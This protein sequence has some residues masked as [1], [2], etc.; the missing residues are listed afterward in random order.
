MIQAFVSF[1]NFSDSD[2]STKK[3]AGI[4][5]DDSWQNPAKEISKRKTLVFLF[6]HK[7]HLFS[8]DKKENVRIFLLIP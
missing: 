3:N 7:Q 4:S 6:Y 1:C 5:C 2:I 8:S